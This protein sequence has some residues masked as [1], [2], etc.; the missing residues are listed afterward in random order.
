MS[1]AI[2]GTVQHNAIDTSGTTLDVTITVSAGDLVAIWDKLFVRAERKAGGTRGKYM[3]IER[4]Q[5]TDDDLKRIEAELPAVAGER[6]DEA[7]MAA[8]N[9]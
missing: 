9:L 3:K 4:A 8:L 7:G 6:Y 5:Y 1:V 2:H